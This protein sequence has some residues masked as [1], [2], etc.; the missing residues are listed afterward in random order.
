MR[1]ENSRISA[2]LNHLQ[3]NLKGPVK[4]RQDIRMELETHLYELYE[5]C[6][7]GGCGEEDAAKNAIDE[8][9][10]A[11]SLICEYNEVF[12]RKRKRKIL[13][14][15]L[16]M[17]A[18]CTTLCLC[19]AFYNMQSRQNK[20]LEFCRGADDGTV[21]LSPPLKEELYSPH[22]YK[23]DILTSAINNYHSEVRSCHFIQMAVNEDFILT[24]GEVYDNP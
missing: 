12:Y 7:S 15:S 24:M 17:T 20:Y 22:S 11:E 2:W 4:Y 10:N 9:G 19:A 14:A 8:M 6:L 18:I 21:V 13:R 5:A 3:R 1:E 23:S 16:S